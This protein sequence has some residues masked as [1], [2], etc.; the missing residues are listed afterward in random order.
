MNKNKAQTALS[1]FFV[2]LMIIA[3]SFIIIYPLVYMVSMAFRE[4]GD[5]LD[6]AVIW[7]PKNYTL[8]NLKTAMKFLDYPAALLRTA[9]LSLGCAV[10][11]CFT[12][13]IVGYGFARFRFR[14]N[15]VLF[16]VVLFTLMVPSQIISMPLFLTFRNFDFAGLGSLLKGLTGYGFSFNLINTPVPMMAQA[17]FGTGIR[18]GL[19]IYIFRQSFK[20]APKVLE[21][22]AYID[23]CSSVGTFFKIMLPNAGAVLMIAFLFSLVWYWNDYFYSAMFYNKSMPLSVLLSN[24]GSML[25]A[26]HKPDG[27]QYFLNDSYVI[28]QAACLLYIT[29]PLLLYLFLQKQF[30][31]SVERSGIVG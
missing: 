21:E 2:Y 9:L 11:Q 10:L 18:A 15:T 4:S 23:G 5:V 24:I 7:I 13:A 29:P 16:M 30:V 6:P 17:L 3:V 19:F 28:K 26:A 1:R 27:T 12:T 8:E 25:S 31:E 14:G 20:N 22:A